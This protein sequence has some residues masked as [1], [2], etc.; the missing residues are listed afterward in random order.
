M[1]RPLFYNLHYLH[2]SS[3]SFRSD[4]IVVHEID[5]VHLMGLSGPNQKSSVIIIIAITIIIIS[6]TISPS[7]VKFPEAYA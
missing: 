7:V 5:L 2:L 6:V 3:K 4:G 1:L